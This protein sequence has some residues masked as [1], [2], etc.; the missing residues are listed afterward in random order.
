MASKKRTGGRT[1]LM[2]HKGTKLT[3]REGMNGECELVIGAHHAPAQAKTFNGAV[4]EGVTWLLV[5]GG[6]M[7]ATKYERTGRES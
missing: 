2:S 6:T 5:N 4:R 3:V 1:F 7:D